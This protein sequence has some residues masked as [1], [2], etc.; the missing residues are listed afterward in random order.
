MITIK[1]MI[2]TIANGIQSGERTHTHDQLA[3]APIPASFNTMNT[4][5]S[6]PLKPIPVEEL[7]FSFAI[8][9]NYS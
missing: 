6:N 1:I 7:L 2:K 3:T 4:I 9:F 5:A 8:F